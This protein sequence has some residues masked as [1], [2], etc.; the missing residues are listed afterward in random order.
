[1][2]LG[3]LGR[4]VALTIALGPVLATAQEP[5]PPAPCTAEEYR[6]FD[7][8]IGSWEVT[9]PDG[10]VAGTNA[11]DSILNGCVLREQWR[12]AG[13]MT[14]T[15]YNTYDPHA[16]TWHQTW[17]DDRGGFLLLSGRLEEGS[18]VLRGEMVD[19]EGPVLHRITWTPVATG[20]V[21]QFWEASRDGGTTWSVVFDGR[22]APTGASSAGNGAD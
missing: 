8:W 22:Y 2:S 17:V 3:M 1:M 20:E 21:R 16:G 12:G 14:G 15:S 11:I 4:L 5:E 7:F 9:T 13:G 19:D 18:M 6:Q 10:N